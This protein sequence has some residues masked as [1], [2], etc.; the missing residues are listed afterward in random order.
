MNIGIRL[1]VLLVCTLTSLMVSG[2]NPQKPDPVSVDIITYRFYIEKR[3]DSLIAAGKQAL[4]QEIDFYYLRVRMG[5]A[6]YETGRY[7]PAVPHLKKAHE[8]NPADD[9]VNSYYYYALRYTNQPEEA[10]RVLKYMSPETRRSVEAASGLI[11]SAQTA[12]GYTFSSAEKSKKK[13]SL[14][15]SDSIYGEQDLYGDNSYAALGLNFRI[16]RR[17]GLT[18]A[19]N[20]LQ[21]H[22]ARYIQYGRGEDHLTSVRDTTVGQFTDSIYYYEFPWVI[23]DTSFQYEVKQHEVYLSASIA[24]GAGFRIV[25]AFRMVRVGYPAT[26]IS[27]RFDTVQDPYYYKE[28]GNIYYTFPYARLKYTFRQNDTSFSNYL[29]SLRITKDLNFL[30][31][32]FSGSWSNLNGKTQKQAGLSLS[33]FPLGNQNLYGSTVVSGFF[34]NSEKRLLF[35]Q[36][37]GGKLLPWLWAEGNFHYGDYTNANILNG[38]VVFNSSDRMKYRAGGTLVFIAGRK[39]HLSLTYQYASKES[40]QYYYQKTTNPINGEINEIQQVK[41]NPYHTQSI[42]GGVAWKL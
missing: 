26:D 2:E 7:F 40:L 32:G 15:G 9:F 14:M 5:V 41:Y 3:W 37:V 29:V 16:C 20:Y 4:Q 30:S 13:S 36:V 22:K 8:E 23:Y 11:Q 21:F 17:I 12:A 31:L 34:Q 25:P 1:I 39:L 35:S 33:Y 27:F 10:E 24:A 18:V 42:I 38:S 19:Y 6:Y 28:E